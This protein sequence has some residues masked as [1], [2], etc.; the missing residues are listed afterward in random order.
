MRK[1]KYPKLF[2]FH[3]TNDQFN[4]L[5]DKSNNHKISIAELIRELIDGH[6]CK[7]MISKKLEEM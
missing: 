4:F 6:I 1:S 7:K 2:Q 3:L 5:N